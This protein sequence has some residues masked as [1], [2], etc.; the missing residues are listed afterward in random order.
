MI[1][2]VVNEES[3]TFEAKNETIYY[4]ISFAG[5]LV[6]SFSV[7]KRVNVSIFLKKLIDMKKKK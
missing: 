4:L 7:K 1:S 3:T 6:I 2:L 5:G